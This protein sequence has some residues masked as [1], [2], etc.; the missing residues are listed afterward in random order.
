MNFT[1]GGDLL[2]TPRHVYCNAVSDNI[3]LPLQPHQ[4]KGLPDQAGDGLGSALAVQHAE[5]AQLRSQMASLRQDLHAAAAAPNQ[6]CAKPN[7]Q[8]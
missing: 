1:E 7:S 8:E 2:K 3:K 6:V 4:Q 5:L